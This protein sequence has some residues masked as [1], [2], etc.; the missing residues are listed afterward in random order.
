MWMDFFGRRQP[1]K[2]SSARRKPNRRRQRNPQRR[3][4]AETLE[5]RMLLTVFGQLANLA[6]P[7]GFVLTSAIPQD[8]AGH[9][10][11]SAGDV[12]RDGYDDLLI[13]APVD[14]NFPAGNGT[15]YLVY[16]KADSFSNLTLEVTFEPDGF[17]IYGL[18]NNDFAGFSVSDAGDINGDGFHD[19]LIGAPGAD[20]PH[21]NGPVYGNGESYVVFGGEFT[22]ANR[23]TLFNLDGTNGFK[24]LGNAA[25]D[26]SGFSV[27]S[28]GDV[29]GD[30][31][32]DLIIGARFVD[33]TYLYDNTGRSYLLFGKADGFTPTMNVWEL[34]S[35]GDGLVING[36]D[37]Y[38]YAGFSVSDAGDINGDGYADFAIGAPFADKPAQ[39][40]LLFGAGEGYLI[41]GGPS[42]ESDVTQLDGTNGFRIAGFATYDRAGYSVSSA[43]DIN[44]DGIDDLLISAPA[45]RAVAVTPGQSYVIFGKESGF[46]PVLDLGSL[47]GT[48]GFSLFGIDYADHAGWSV[49]GAGDINGDGID[50]LL[51]GA[52]FGDQ[53][54]GGLAYYGVGEVYVVFGRD[55][56][57]PNRVVLGALGDDEGFILLGEAAYARTGFS[58]S[59]AGD[60]NG[61]GFDDFIIGAPSD[62]D[63]TSRPGR[64]YVLFG[65]DFTGKNPQT[66]DN[67]DNTLTGTA[68]A[69]V[70]IG[71]QGDDLLR[72]NGGADV[73]RGGQGNDTI[74]LTDLTFRLFDGG[75]GEDTLKFDGADLSLDLSAVYDNR[76][77]GLEHIDLTGSGDN[78]LT[79]GNVREVL[80]ISDTSNRLIVHRDAGDT[81]DLGEGWTETTAETID[82][83]VFRVFTQGAAE[84]LV[85]NL[86]PT[87]DL[88]GPDGDG[89]DTSATFTEDG[90]AVLIVDPNVTVADDDRIVSATI[91]LTNLLDGTDESLALTV[92]GT[93]LQTTYNSTTG[94]LHVTGTATAS[95]Y[96]AALATLRYR[97]ADD[98][99]DITDRVVTVTVDDGLIA[100]DPARATVSLIA[101]NDAPLLA[102]TPVQLDTIVE[103]DRDSGG[104]TVADLIPAGNITDPDGVATEAI[105]VILADQTHGVWQYST[106]GDWQDLGI[107]SLTAARLLGP[108][109][110]VRFV[111]AADYNGT[112]T[113]RFKAWDQTSG[114]AGEEADVVTTG[115]T[116][117][118]ST[119][120]AT[121]TIS[122]TPVN[123]APILDDTPSPMLTPI[124]REQVHSAGDLVSVLVAGAITDIDGPPRSSI[125]VIDVDET[126]GHWEHLLPGTTLPQWTRITASE[127]AATLLS[128]ARRIRFV[129]NIGFS[130]TAAITFRAWDQ[131]AGGDGGLADTTQHGGSTPFSIATDSAEITV[132][133]TDD[134]PTLNP[135]GS[136]LILNT[137]NPHPVN[138][139]NITD[140]GARSEIL[141]VSTVSSNHAVLP[142]PEVT[143]N[144]PGTTGQLLLAPIVDAGGWSVVT[145]TVTEDDGD[146]IS[147]TFAVSVGDNPQRWQNPFEAKDVNTDGVITPNDVLIIINE[148]NG[149][150]HADSSG[151]LPTP[152]NSVPPPYYDVTGDGFVTPRD[153]LVVVNC[154]NSAASQGGEGEGVGPTEGVGSVEGLSG[155]GLG[156]TVGTSGTGSS[157]V[158]ASDLARPPV[159]PARER[160]LAGGTGSRVASSAA[161]APTADTRQRIFA[162]SGSSRTDAELDSILD[163]LGT[164]ELA[165]WW[166]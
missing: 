158:A 19:F 2:S 59:S 152:S 150:N 70:Q 97:N 67:E 96:V 153:A 39:G 148:L 141:T 107:P 111:P 49:S 12:N 35:N 159:S 37:P 95:V 108:T 134:P 82:G 51:I 118:F 44:G 110:K 124:S 165:R 98:G 132:R 53:Y 26:R 27:S 119:G 17:P 62:Y 121:A 11:S 76:L 117:P 71:G 18:N 38:D 112:A 46:D 64:A 84:L 94:V 143:Y 120:K 42:I 3:L 127:S 25:Y 81:V 73:A 57:F 90:P 24:I 89:T 60:V 137:T 48:N 113:F 85:Q 13:G 102:G 14:D 36:I 29:N 50:D 6:P 160:H 133:A 74:L 126:N 130:G 106:G 131:S 125:A 32:D 16:G 105:A 45:D 147:R 23:P 142:D 116:T 8:Q 92:S 55:T 93:G 77:V 54:S 140:G 43:G 115:G 128:F 66:G 72:G 156:L 149:H 166:S 56:G 68:Q 21:P 87:I 144:A 138:L 61:D 7:E 139:T 101:I 155:A 88:N 104:T 100:S 163:A 91:T 109:D 5:D 162:A 122:V 69:E 4:L 31:F 151:R 154:L 80:N 136:P 157:F 33:Q 47:D 52:P 10:V 145:V 15:A 78:H 135:I 63:Y 40:G 123:D 164:D 30:G 146:A 103:D 86:K 79:I 65:R 34:E 9:S 41:F 129:P 20:R 28:A 22:V 75:R 99:A 58:V 1:G 114:S 83:V 161:A